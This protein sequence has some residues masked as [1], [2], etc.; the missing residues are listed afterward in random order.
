MKK[1]SDK[2]V[3]N[4]RKTKSKKT[5]PLVINEITPADK[6]DGENLNPIHFPI[7]GIGASAGGLE[8]IEDFFRSMKPQPEAAFVLIQHISPDHKSFMNELLHRCTQIPVEVAKNGTPVAINNI[9]L[10]PPGMNLTIKEGILYTEKVV[11]RGLNL[12]IDI[13]LRS[14]A[15]D[16][17]PNAVGIILSGTGS[18]GTLGMRMIKEF[19]G[20]TLVQSDR[21]A[22]FDG[23]PKSA[24]ST[25][26]I[27]IVRPAKEL[28]G[29]L[30]SFLQNP[31]FLH[32]SL[33]ESMLLRNQRLYKRIITILRDQKNV[34]FSMYKDATII[35]RLEKR[36]S[37]NRFEKVS[38]YVTYLSRT[39]MEVDI[40]FNEILIGVTHFFRDLEAFDVLEKQTIE[41]LFNEHKDKD[42][43][44]IWIPGC[45]T[46]EEAY[47]LTMIIREYMC[48][49]QITADVRIF[50]TDIDE[51]S[52][53]Y[54]A[55]GFYPGN[56]SMEVPPQYLLK[57]F[58][59]HG[60][61]F[62]INAEIRRMI[63]F[64]RQNVIEDPPF[65]KVDMISCRN[66][67]IY[68]NPEI[69]HRVLSSFYSGLQTGGILF[70]GPSESLGKFSDLFTTINHKWKI[71]QKRSGVTPSEL[72]HAPI[73]SQL[74]LSKVDPIHTTTSST[75]DNRLILDLL[76]KINNAF[77]PPS[78]VIDS[79]GEIIY[80][81]G[82]VKDFLQVATGKMTTNLL[83]MLSRDISIIVSSL[84]RRS[85]KS[86]Q[87][88]SIETIYNKKTLMIQC[89][90]II[91]TIDNFAYCY[92]VFNWLS[93]KENLTL[94]SAVDE[95]NISIRYQERIDD[96][97]SEIHFQKENLQSAVEEL[98]SSNEELQASNEELIASNEELQSTNEELQ[99]V[100]EELY[101]VNTEHVAKLAEIS[102]LN[103]DYDNLLSNTFIGTLF[104][105]KNMIIRKISRI[106]S[107]LTNILQTDVGRPLYHLSLNTL[108]PKFIQD[109]RKV[110]E[111]K[112]RIE[113]E[114][115]YDGR[116]YLMR[117]VPY[118]VDKKT[119]SG[120]IISF[121]DL[122]ES[123]ITTLAHL[124]TKVKKVKKASKTST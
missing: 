123:K 46:G 22:K 107:E 2:T 61:G 85:Q 113:K 32:G 77:L 108:Y 118:L 1:T 66:F 17:G 62:Q 27:D 11:D 39:P 19:G 56:I 9:Y 35:R 49:K 74:R 117:I 3:A 109:V 14:L 93:A 33:I 15:K 87:I 50:A 41:T 88:I 25:G 6:R 8:A 112:K 63:I 69:Q 124:K 94:S 16:Q 51:K 70:L 24:I 116:F 44:R 111:T 21:D 57:Y 90:R 12:P 82:N 23:M 64:A 7:V 91:S 4:K 20:M 102:E 42:E 30:C 18:D 114:L 79:A 121:V 52:L 96:L 99:S 81:I 47:S 45:S 86:D 98:E 34:D 31:L 60:N 75:Q 29:E 84:I 28:A 122:S 40:L 13:F 55:T 43:I 54:A 38:D 26:L 76:E 120:I 100:N 97:E 95:Q 5:V 73:N 80:T 37:I 72:Y 10:I 101:T 59:P 103:A 104:L 71:Y 58:T 89:K 92:I 110:N 78:L 106:A 115:P 48:K 53:K 68:I 119:I 65:F 105:D 83:K 67:L 36:I